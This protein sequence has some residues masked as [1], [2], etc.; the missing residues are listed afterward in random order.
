MK[1]KKTTTLLGIVFLLLW[2]SNIPYF[3]SHPFQPHQGIKDLSGELANAP[4]FIKEDAG[5][6]GQKQIDIE[7]IL[8][9]QIRLAWLKSLFFNLIGIFSGILIIRKKNLGRILALG[10]SVFLVGMRL[11]HS[12]QSAHWRDSLSIRYF[13]IRFEYFPVRT[14]HEEITFLILLSTIVLLLTPSIA[15]T[16]KKGRFDNRTT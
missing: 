4:E 9:K 6:G 12:F 13:K 5:I 14:V 10:L 8:T 7:R 1:N 3:F 11:Y 15:A 16:F 2:L